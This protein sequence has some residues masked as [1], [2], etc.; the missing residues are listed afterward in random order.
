M[1]AVVASVFGIGL[2]RDIGIILSVG[3]CADLMNTYLMNVSLLRWHKF[4]GVE[5]LMLEPIE[6][7]L[8][9]PVARRRR[10]RCHGGAVRARIRAGAGPRR[11]RERGPRGDH[12]PP[13]RAG[14]RGRDADPRAAVGIH[15]D[16]RRV[17][18]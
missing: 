1:M 10:D 9:D 4:E 18:G 17:R 16:R 5:T 7:E 15:R 14:P 11:R 12:E 3:L 6:G 2:L 8:A 13:V